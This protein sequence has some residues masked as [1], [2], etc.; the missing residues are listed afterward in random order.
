MVDMRLSL[1]SA[2]ILLALALLVPTIP[3]SRTD[4]L[5]QQAAR[6]EA[7]DL[8][9]GVTALKAGDVDSAERVFSE[10]LRLGMKTP[11]VYHNLGI[12]AQ[13]RGEHANAIAN[14]R[15][16]IQLQPAY[17][18]AHL[19]LGVSLAALDK[20]DEAVHE[21]ERAVRLMPAEPQ[22]R[23]QLAMAREA[24]GDKLG[25]TREFEKLA[26]LAPEN[27]EYAYLLGKSWTV[28]SQWSLRKIAALDP[29]SARLHQALA[30]EHAT[31]G[32][33]EQAIASYRKAAAIDPKLPEI[34]L[35]IAKIYFEQT[36][37]ED[38]LAETNDELKVIPESR[39]ALEMKSQIEKAQAGADR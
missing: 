15:K 38:A 5:A 17:G 30:Q 13:Q 33:L 3:G 23:L 25:A 34:H 11:L 8:Q 10:A 26:R 28:L 6:P 24:L 18:P 19:L 22:V 7:P 12:I 35:A 39:A 29:N 9:A 1:T 16:V 37:Y 31:Q 32:H 14:F 36:K 27:A 2:R 4:V 21:L 20:N